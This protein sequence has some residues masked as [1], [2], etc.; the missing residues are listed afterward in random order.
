VNKR[1][2]VFRLDGTFVKEVFVARSSRV[3]RGVP[4]GLALSRDRDQQF[5]YV[6]DTANSHVWILNRHT[7]EVAGKFGRRGRYAGQ[8]MM[9]H[10]IAVDSKGNIYT[11]EGIIGRRAQKF[12]VTGLSSAPSH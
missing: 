1:V 6:A 2:Q 12:V 8:W 3:D 10:G 5:L 11:G 7:L 4:D 9:L